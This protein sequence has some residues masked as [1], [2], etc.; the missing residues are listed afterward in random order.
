MLVPVRRGL[1]GPQ[2]TARVRQRRGAG[3]GVTGAGPRPRSGARGGGR[4]TAPGMPH[5]VGNW[6]RQ[7]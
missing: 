1:H 5:D 4:T 6:S 7:P 3:C 2:S